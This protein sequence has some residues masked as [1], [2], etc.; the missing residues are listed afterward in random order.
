[1]V[2]SANEIEYARV[3]SEYALRLQCEEDF[4]TFVREAWPHIEGGK[5]FV[6]GEAVMAMADHL[7]EVYY[8][9]IKRLNINIPPRCTKPVSS[10]SYIF[11]KEFGLIRL[12]EVLSDM[13]VL[14]HRGIFRKVLSVHH[15]GKLPTL[16]IS[17]SRG[18]KIKA[19]KSHVFL[20][21]NGWTSCGDLRVDD[22][23]GAVMVQGDSGKPVLLEEARLI[24]YLIGDG[25]C[26]ST[27]RVTV[28]DQIEEDD[29]KRCVSACGFYSY[30]TAYRVSKTGR[31]YGY[32]SIR[33]S[34]HGIPYGRR[35]TK[36]A[37]GPVRQWMMSRGLYG[38][39]S[40]NKTVPDIIMRGTKEVVINYLAAYWACDGH[41]S[42]RGGKGRNRELRKDIVIGCD[43]VNMELMRQTQLL[44]Q[45]LG[46][47]SNLRKKVANI[48][49]AR[50]GDNYTSWKLSL[51]CQDDC[52][53]FVSLIKIP[54]LKQSQVAKSLKRRFDFDRVIEGES[55]I[56]IKDGGLQECMCLEVETDNSFVANGI[57]VHNSNT[58]SCLFP[59]WCWIRNSGLQLLTVS[60]LERLAIRDNVKSRRLIK[61][62]W[63]Q[64]RWGDRIT[65]SDDQSTK[66]RVDNNQGGYREAA[67]L[68]A[69]LTGTGG[70][71]II[72]DDANNVKDQSDIA[73]ENALDVWQ[74]IL[75]T[76]FNDF[77]T[78][79]LINVQQR[80]N[81][82]DISGYIINHQKGEFVNL[83]LPMEFESAHRCVTV[84]TKRTG[85]KRWQDWRQKDGELLVPD[86]I[87]AI[88]LASLK[89]ALGSEYSCNPYEAPVL[90]GDLSLKPIGSVAVGDEVIGWSFPD[91]PMDETSKYA[92]QHLRCTKVLEVF[93]SVKPIVKITL[94][95]GEVIR[96]TPDH[97][98]YVRWRKERTTGEY[99][100]ATVGRGLCRICPPRL[101]VLSPEEERDA[102]WLAGFF[103]GEG[104]VSM[105]GKEAGYRASAAIS[106]FQGAGRNKPLC[107]NLE[108]VLARFGFEYHIYEDIRPD[109]KNCGMYPYRH[110]KIKGIG[111]PTLQRF[112]H[113]IRPLKWRQ[114]MID[115]ALGAQ[116]IKSHEKVVSIEPDG[117]DK[118][119][120][121]KTETG[122]YVVWGLASKNCAGQ[123]QQRPAPAEGGMIKRGWFQPWK[124]DKPPRCS[125]IIQSWDTAMSAKKEAAYSACTTWGVFKNDVGVSCM[126]LLGAWR[127]KVE[128]HELY[129]QVQR[130][131]R[132][133][134]ATTDK[135]QIRASNKPDIVLVEA[136][137]SGHQILQTLN[138]TGLILTPWNP[139]KYGD[140]VERV[141]KITHILEAGRVFV[142]MRGPDFKRMV[143]YADLV[144][145][146]AAVFPK[147]ESKDMVDTMTS[148]IQR[149]INSGWVMH[150]EEAAAEAEAERRREY[151]QP[152][153]SGGFY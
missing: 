11:T 6:G 100:P 84:P 60:Y 18:R 140:K 81:E 79:R 101:A 45:R 126:I 37:Y 63:F 48:K 112:L 44:L 39:N 151:E 32:I 116:F 4:Y 54:H 28:C 91:K 35:R 2:S 58:V 120:S 125:Y 42:I 31:D 64:A 117:E 144:T 127:G 41:I 72:L 137:A 57:A 102:C 93:S 56:S 131:A 119:Y 52:Y 80:T 19:E 132:D 78:G 122:N 94:D 149:V 46:I 114:R 118:V 33:E 108:R 15:Q 103:D 104:S 75:P 98:W 1:M 134:T 14:S 96:C 87:G 90:M 115:G 92:R 111:L 152:E 34:E 89:R 105:C 150:P 109:K 71:I 128:F 21:A 136:K 67:G 82:R 22:V 26:Q 145:S 123:L 83:I 66:N 13:H 12:C 69:G 133:Y 148:A 9:R 77:K 53:K 24:G 7:E 49:T 23:L 129:K 47:N 51:T 95:S 27:P 153:Q 61:S 59:V 10:D 16:E 5:P 68:D 20:T 86:R 124:D 74:N 142:P 139:D 97:K 130:M 3:L 110:Y 38:K 143:T 43:S 147:G 25:S 85:G 17:T 55:I 106:F 29:I 141:R 8:G 36:G 70:D 99:L 138:R 50:Q 65:L 135:S 73:L 40:Y 76:R 62:D 146:Q 88:E 121:F 30:H 107:D 113:L